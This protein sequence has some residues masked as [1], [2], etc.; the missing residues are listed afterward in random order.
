MGRVGMSLG[1]H[2]DGF[3]NVYANKGSEYCGGCP[4]DFIGCRITDRAL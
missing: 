3:A 2:L 1:K 4:P